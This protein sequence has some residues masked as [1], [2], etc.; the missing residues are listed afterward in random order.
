MIKISEW[1]NFKFY[2]NGEWPV[3]NRPCLT[4]RNFVICNDCGKWRMAIFKNEKIQKMATFKNWPFTSNLVIRWSGP[5]LKC[6]RVHFSTRIYNNF[7]KNSLLSSSLYDEHCWLMKV[8]RFLNDL[9]SIL[10]KFFV[11]CGVTWLVCTIWNK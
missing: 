8:S 4:I 10:V 5:S 7:Y 3:R 11:S 1:P 6:C 2:Q 9:S